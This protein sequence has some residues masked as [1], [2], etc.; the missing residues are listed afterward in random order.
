[1]NY[2]LQPWMVLQQGVV[3]IQF[4]RDGQLLDIY[5]HSKELNHNT[6]HYDR[7]F[8]GVG[9]SYIIVFLLCHMWSTVL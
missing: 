4:D 2:K 7:H 1:M 9:L 8:V 6:H 5:E 3:G